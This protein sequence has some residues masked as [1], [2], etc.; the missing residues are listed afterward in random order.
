MAD[1]KFNPENAL[2]I[3]ITE[4]SRLQLCELIMQLCARVKEDAGVSYRGGIFPANISMDENGA[5]YIG[6]S[7]GDVC[8]G[9]ELDFIAPD[10]YWNGRRSP[11]ADVYSL[12]MLMYYALSEGK[13]PF[14]GDKDALKRRMSGE[15][16]PAPAAAGRRLGDIILKASAFMAA[17]RYQSVDELKSV[18]ESCNT[19][20]FLKGVSSSEDIFRKNDD[21]LSD[22]ERMMVDIMEK[23]EPPIE[24]EEIKVYDPAK[25]TAVDA[26]EQEVIDINKD[27][28]FDVK[29]LEIKSDEP[30]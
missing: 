14:D 16:F 15:S 6:P 4:L 28:E 7:A 21:D 5:A 20:L 24:A 10:L 13:L 27:T 23:E 9:E 11:A 1:T 3:K 25:A 18:I 29:T 2:G 22:I 8:E 26:A 17:E 19:N 30:K 12:G